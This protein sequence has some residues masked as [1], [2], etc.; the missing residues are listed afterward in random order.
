MAEEEI[1]CLC[2][3]AKTIMMAQPMLLELRP[4]IN[5]CGD[6]HGQFEDLKK[7]FNLVG[8]PETGQNYLFLGDYIDRGK[9]SL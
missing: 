6:L 5:I 8:Y 7:L 9:L 2:F 1:A 3:F 4:P